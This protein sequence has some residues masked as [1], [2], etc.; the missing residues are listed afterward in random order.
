MPTALAILV[1][2]QAGEFPVLE[3]ADHALGFP[4]AHLLV[5]RIQELLPG[6]GSGEGGAVVQGAAEAAEVQQA[7]G[8]AVEGHAQ[9][10]HHVDDRGRGFAHG[11]DGGL[12]AQEVA[13]L[14][15]VHEVDVGGVAFAL[16]VDGAVDAAL[17]ADRVAALDVHHAEDVDLEAQF[18][19]LHGGR[20]ACQASAD[21]QDSLLAHIRCPRVW[22]ACLEDHSSA[23][24]VFC[25]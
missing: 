8:S 3:L 25:S 22:D 14:D 17:G 13:A 19:G 15:R 18:A 16:G 7:F 12:V 4:A 10:V 9:A 1:Q 23:T 20:E 21:D 6:G 11:E 24:E 5:Q 2:D